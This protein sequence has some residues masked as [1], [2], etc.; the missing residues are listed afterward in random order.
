MQ[1]LRPHKLERH[2]KFFSAFAQYKP[3]NASF[4]LE[5]QSTRP[6]QDTTTTSQPTSTNMAGEAHSTSAGSPMAKASIRPLHVM[7]TI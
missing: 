4:R 2:V 7:N 5:R 6:S 3:T 1:V